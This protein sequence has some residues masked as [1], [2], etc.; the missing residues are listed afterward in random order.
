MPAGS[1]NFS[2]VG[3]VPVSRVARDSVGE[4]LLVGSVGVKETTGVASTSQAL[5]VGQGTNVGASV[6]GTTVTGVD[7]AASDPAQPKAA[8]TTS[9]PSK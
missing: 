5:V 6:G 2:N 8:A 4:L 3:F 7:V 9:A 1:G